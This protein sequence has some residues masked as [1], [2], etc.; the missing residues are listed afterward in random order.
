MLVRSPVL[1]RLHRATTAST[2]GLA[3]GSGVP[4]QLT[5]I[6]KPPSVP[7]TIGGGGVGEGTGAAPAS[8]TRTVA[9]ALRPSLSAITVTSPTVEALSSPPALTVAL[10]PP[11]R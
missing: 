3:R 6:E 7:A 5:R 10:P 4:T 11:R 8:T 2:S 9:V 1:A